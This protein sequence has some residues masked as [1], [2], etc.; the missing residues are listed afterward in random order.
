M[1]NSRRHIALVLLVALP[2]IGGVKPASA[3]GIF[4]SG[5]ITVSNDLSS[6]ARITFND[7]QATVI[8]EFSAVGAATNPQEA[9]SS[10]VNGVV[11]DAVP[12]VVTNGTSWS[13]CLS[14]AGAA[15]TTGS[16]TYTL[17][18]TGATGD[19]LIVKTCTV[20]SGHMTCAAL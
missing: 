12:V 10:D 18:A 7:P 17:E 13:G 15:V 5:T 3:V 14:G 6:C 20:S 16:A 1:R 9:S 2:V 19:I 8:G 4:A 11:L